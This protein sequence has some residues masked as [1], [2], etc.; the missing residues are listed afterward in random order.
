MIFV[1]NRKLKTKKYKLIRIQQESVG[2]C[3]LNRIAL[4]SV[5]YYT[6][7]IE[8]IHAISAAAKSILF[9]EKKNANFGGRNI[10]RQMDCGKCSSTGWF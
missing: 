4:C 9:L 5:H 2:D 1:P 10:P 7:K 6:T 3:T 8:S